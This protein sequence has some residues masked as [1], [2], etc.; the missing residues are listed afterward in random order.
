[1]KADED[2]IAQCRAQGLYPLGYYP[3]NIHFIWMGAT[4]RARAS[5][6]STSARKVAA[7][8]PTRRSQSSPI[9]QGFLVVPYWA[10]VR[11]GRWDEILAEPAPSDTLYTRALA[12]R[13]RT[14]VLRKGQV[15]EAER[16][17]PARGSAQDPSPTR[18]RVPTLPPDHSSLAS[19]PRSSPARSP[20]A[21]DYDVAIAHLEPAVR[22]E[23]GLVY[24]EPSDWHY[25]PRHAFGAALLAAGRRAKPETVYWED[26]KRNRENGWALF[27]LASHSLPRAREHAALV[28]Q[29]FEKA[30]ARADVKLTASRF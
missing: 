1:M 4:S 26:L 21:K 13:A 14:G 6:R 27:G 16:D 3:H 30:W 17:S 11:F 28:E 9:L 15:E 24:T 22:I 29:R 12:L 20:P 19:P 8:V 5:S 7:S 10:M 23:D 18:C 2:Y 25:P